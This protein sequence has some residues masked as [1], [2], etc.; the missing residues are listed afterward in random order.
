MKQ[1][2][3]DIGGD[4]PMRFENF[5]V[6]DN[7]ALLAA[8]HEAALAGGEPLYLWGTPGSGRT[9]LLEATRALAL[10]AGRQ[11]TCFAGGRDELQIG[12]P[13][14]VL[15]DDV[16]HLD[17]QDQVALFNLFNRS[18]SRGQTIA[19]SGPCAPRELRLREDLRTRIGQA[20]SF[21]IQP[22]ADGQ[23]REI[24]L[25]LAARRAVKLDDEVVEFLLRHGR[26][27]LPSL[28]TVFDALDRASLEFK[29]PITLPLLR[30][31]MQGGLD[32]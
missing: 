12:N 8:L 10:D 24:M 23:R 29:R 31:L 21:E 30:R 26:R 13:S 2:L 19:L 14:L 9:H 22:L 16:E 3:L 4:A 7:G 18:R 32:L 17:D 6:G 27:D 15:V 20:L 5:V 11:A 25:Q 1:L 28:V